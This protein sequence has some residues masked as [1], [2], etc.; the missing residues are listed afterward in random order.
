MQ[1]LLSSLVVGWLSNREGRLSEAIEQAVNG[2][3]ATLRRTAN[4]QSRDK[5]SGT[6]PSIRVRSKELRL[7]QSQAEIVS[8]PPLAKV[9]PL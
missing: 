7:I 8:P 3:Q 1:D 4:M 6:D 9:E 2:L 5:A